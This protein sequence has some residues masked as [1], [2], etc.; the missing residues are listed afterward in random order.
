MKA[1]AERPGERS[2]AP[3]AKHPEPVPQPTPTAWWGVTPRTACLLAGLSTAV[4]WSYWPDFADMARKW[5][6]DPQYSH[7]YLVPAFSVYLLWVRR[8]IDPQAGIPASAGADPLR[9][10]HVRRYPGPGWWGLSILAGGVFLRLVGSYLYFDWL[11]AVS[12]LLVLAGAA[13]LLAGPRM[14]WWSGRPSASSYS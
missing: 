3:A 7:A 12:L 9:R 14:L 4:L 10:R 8:P 11:E 5:A 13:L 1:Q 6:Q 2:P